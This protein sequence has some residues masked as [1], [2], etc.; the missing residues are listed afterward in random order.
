MSTAS[1]LAQ[2]IA[3]DGVTVSNVVFTGAN[4]SAGTFAGAGTEASSVGFDN[5]VVLSSGRVAGVSTSCASGKG[6]EGPNVCT[7]NT[8][9]NGTAGDAALT[10]LAGV[11]TFDAS[12]LQF[13]FVPQ[14]STVQFQYVF[15]SEEYLEYV[16]QGVNDTFGFFVNGVNCATVPG[17]EG[18]PVSVDTINTGVNAGFFRNNA[19]AS[20][21]TELDGVT[22]VLECDA[23]VDPGVTNTMRLAIADGGDSILDSAAFIR[24][25]SLI[26]GTQVSGSLAGGDESG[27]S[28]SVPTGTPVT[29]ERNAQRGECLLSRRNRDLLGVLRRLVHRFSRIRRNQDGLRRYGAGFRCGDA[30]HRRDVLL[31]DRLQRRFV[32]QP[33]VDH[34]W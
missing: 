20:I 2:M 9:D 27:A 24:A 19:A 34:L 28:I 1:Q 23:A 8:T 7:D 32:E 25:G 6:I 18:T 11:N 16:N 31:E 13:D 3:G 5:G 33:V 12:I 10:A 15:G 29:A 17:T 14:F 4:V 26:S 30:Q 22:T 21:D